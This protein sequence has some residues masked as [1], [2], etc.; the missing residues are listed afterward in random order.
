[1]EKKGSRSGGSEIKFGTDG[2]RAGIARE[3]TFDNVARVAQATARFLL[4][5]KRKDLAI[6]RDW[7]SPYRPAVDGVIVGYDMRFLS[8]EFAHHFARVL[9]DS[10]IPVAVSDA[11]VPTPALSYAVVDRNVAAGIMFT[12]SHNPATDNGIKYKAEYGGS[13]PGEVTSGVE[14]FLPHTAPVPHSPKEAID[15]INLRTPFLEKVRTLVD[16]DRLTASPVYVVIDSMYGSA[17]GYVSQLLGEY[18]VPYTNIRGRH[19]TLFGGKKPEPIE[20]NLVPLRAVIA[21]LR[22]RKHNLIGVVTDGDGDRI[23]AMDEKGGFIDAHR[24]FALILRYLVEVRGL[25]GS[26]ITA[27]NLTDMARDMCEDYGLTQIVVPIGFKHHCEKILKRGDVLIGAEESGSIA[28]QGHIPERDG[29]LHSILL[30]EIVA[31]AGRP[32]SELVQSLI[33]N[34]GPRVYQRRDL[35]VEERLEV[36]ARLRENP[37]ERFGNRRV[38]AVETMDGIKLRFDEG[39]LL[40]RASGTEPILRIYC[41]MRE[42]KDV[43]NLLEEAERLARGD[44]TLW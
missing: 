25:R 2:W 12:A 15:E 28:I 8:R 1:V 32:A 5:E 20:E 42:R 21:S 40:F 34:Y 16:P 44:L 19:D 38:I 29:V 33:D 31:S 10:G 39:W 4:D 6:Y 35:K 36:V 3:F 41:E 14:S 13:A 43:L 18:G 22:H 7:G 26:V 17:Q 9:H 30:S 24:T 27:F 37:P 23:S 11:P